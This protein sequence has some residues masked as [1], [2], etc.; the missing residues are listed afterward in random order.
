[1]SSVVLGITNKPDYF[2]VTWESSERENVGF[3]RAANSSRS[4]Y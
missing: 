1:M 3:S 4:A 2:Q